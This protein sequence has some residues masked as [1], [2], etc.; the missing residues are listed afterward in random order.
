MI[1]E[2]DVNNDGTIQLHEFMD[3]MSRKMNNNDRKEEMIHAF[4]IFDINGNG[5]ITAAELRSAMAKM[6]EKLTNE[7][8]E[9]KIRQADKN[10]DGLINYEE[11]V[12]LR[13]ID[14]D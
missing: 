10:N 2:V 3:L 7:D 13:P 12:Q 11:F 6:G 4:R 9:D 1:R 8:V 14:N 5:K